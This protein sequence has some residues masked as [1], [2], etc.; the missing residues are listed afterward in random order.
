MPTDTIYG[1]SCRALDK[2]AVERAHKIKRRDKNKPFVI[3]ISNTSQL[4]ELGVADVDISRISKQWPGKLTIV[5]PAP[6]AP[7]WLHMGGQTLAIRLPDYPELRELIKKTGPLISTSANIQAGRP[8]ENV[9]EA[10]SYFG[11]GLDFYV[12]KGTISGEPST[13]VRYNSGELDL[14]RQGAVK[15]GD[16]E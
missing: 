15:I 3:L 4:Q 12:D 11:E 13:I 8:A 5:C 14:I 16:K 7:R 1:I 10:Q 9:A 2:Q 6:Q